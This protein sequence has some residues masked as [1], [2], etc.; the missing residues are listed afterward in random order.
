MH[1]TCMTLLV[2]A[3]HPRPTA[4]HAVARERSPWQ[5][6]IHRVQIM[7]SLVREAPTCESI[8]NKP[9]NLGFSSA[10]SFLSRV[11]TRCRTAD[12]S[13]LSNG[14]QRNAKLCSTYML[15]ACIL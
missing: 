4:N 1:N 10:A 13:K 12:R 8:S 15:Q 2:H 5:S 14:L 3:E 7:L 9:L 11:Q 6:I